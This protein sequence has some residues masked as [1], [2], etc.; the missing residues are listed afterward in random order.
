MAR[1][2][3]RL[4]RFVFPFQS[5]RE[6]T[7]LGDALRQETV[8]GALLLIAA[9]AALIWVNSPWH[10]GYEHVR[11]FMI[12]PLSV[13]QWASDG[14]LAIFFYVAGLELKRELITG[15]LRRLSL[16]LV[17]VIAAIAG[18]VVPVLLFAT[19][20]L[21]SGD[22]SALGGWAVPTATDIAFA[23]AVLAV[24]GS[25]L[26]SALRAFLLTLAVVDD[27]GAIAVIAVFFTDHLEFAW[28]GLAVL[29]LGVYALAQHR[30][31]TTPFLY[32]PLAVATW[33][34]V[35]ESGLHATVAG[36]AMG[37][38]T[39]VRPDPDED[40]SPAER[41]EHRLRPLSAG[42]AVPVFALAAA[43]VPVTAAA[44]GAMVSDAAAV[45]V[46]VGLVAG[47]TIGVF[48][49]AWLTA[50][51]TRAELNSDLAWRDVF[52]VAVLSGIGF[53]VSLL[54]ADLA[55]AGD[56][57]RVARVKAAVL[58]GSVIAATVATLLLRRRH[59]AYLNMPSESEGEV[60]DSDRAA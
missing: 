33:W 49:G 60:A 38:L 10:G 20:V 52:A 54:V 27:L 13:E 12:G 30:R 6:R 51:L 2:A 32:L 25:A 9:L 43:G 23:L 45:G 58:V 19:V 57:E 4:R 7:F 53:T 37:L 55:F 16:A 1:P 11:E 56:P 31:I 5:G 39:R 48:G 59:R 40:H 8:G 18:M 35:H 28:L 21:G 50:R 15:S 17:P 42:V 3:A 14:L 36:V 34:C 44:L 47:K 26:P 29:L 22:R 46:I 24:A 41:L